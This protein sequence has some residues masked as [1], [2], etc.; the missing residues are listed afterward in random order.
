VYYGV[1]GGVLHVY[2]EYRYGLIWENFASMI[3]SL[4]RNLPLLFVYF[5]VHFG[6]M[7]L[8]GILPGGGVLTVS[9]HCCIVLK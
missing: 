2:A 9:V 7:A 8:C 4:N 1:C 5:A 3:F 6:E